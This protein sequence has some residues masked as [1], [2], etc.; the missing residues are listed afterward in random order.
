VFV[1]RYRGCQ[2]TI[3]CTWCIYLSTDSICKGLLYI[4]SVF[5]SWSRLMTDK[6]IIQGFLQF[7]L[8]SAFRTVWG[9]FLNSHTQPD[10]KQG[11][12]KNSWHI[13][14]LLYLTSSRAAL[15]VPHLN[16]R[17]SFA[18]FEILMFGHM[19]EGNQTL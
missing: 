6:L 17:L 8:M 18:I 3:T 7:R 16:F 15:K 11:I 10:P 2:T 19:A 14:L 9:I 5:F 13:F 12:K 1:R 4:R